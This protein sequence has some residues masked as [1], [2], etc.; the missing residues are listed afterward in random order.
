M[1]IRWTPNIKRGLLVVVIFIATLVSPFK[2]YGTNGRFD[3]DSMMFRI[4]WDLS[5]SSMSFQFLP[6]LNY[7]LPSLL[8]CAPCILWLSKAPNLS[9]PG[10]IGSTGLVVFV[11]TLILLAFL[12]PWAVFPWLFQGYALAIVPEFTDLVPFSGLAFTLMVLFPLIWR[13]LTYSQLQEEI[14]GR[15][16]AAFILTAI[17]LTAPWTIE[18]FSWQGYDINLNYFEGFSLSA[19]SWTMTATVSGN[20]WGQGTWFYFSMS[21]VY[22][23]LALLSLALPGIVFAWFVCRPPYN[24]N[25]TVSML[26]AGIIHLL[27]IFIVCNWTNSTSSHPGT[28]ILA[29]FP[30]L[31]VGGLAIAGIYSFYQLIRRLSVLRD[32]KA[33]ARESE[34]TNV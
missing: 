7:L 12:P 27:S 29:P 32:D 24:R 15:R 10:L 26:A 28:W 25:R 2:I 18:T 4:L 11:L 9:V 6:R 14:M 20:R 21:S 30:T 8:I 19:L 31:I 13:G 22:G 3:I 23:I 33:I 16:V 34:Y 5:E 1:E 17:V